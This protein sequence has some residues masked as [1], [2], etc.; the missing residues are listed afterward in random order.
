MDAA[1]S[2]VAMA[3]RTYGGAAGGPFSYFDGSFCLNLDTDTV[4][5]AEASE[6]YEQLGIDG[7]VE[8]F[9]AEPTPG[10]HHRGCAVSFRRM[11]A[12]AMERG[13][14]HVLILEDDAIWLDDTLAIAARATAEL[15][16]LEWDLCYL[17]ACVWAEVFPF[18]AG[19][20]VLQEAGA[21]TMTHAVAVHSRAFAR[22]LEEIPIEAAPFE[23]WL[24]EYV[25]VDQYLARSIA[26]G[27][28][29]ALITSPRVATQRQLTV[30]DDADGALAGRY[31]I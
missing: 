1:P 25:A 9:S 30:H 21:V 16:D 23:R 17:G 27:T 10:N 29:R 11:V 18:V 14:Q 12:A 8:R 20:S 3:A 13:W 7:W 6:R 22:L 31:V 28:Y 15:D 19:S 4:R 5:W 2:R 26:A 24:D